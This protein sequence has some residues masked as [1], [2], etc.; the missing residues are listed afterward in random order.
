MVW[1]L[2]KAGAIILLVLLVARRLMPPVLERV[3]RTC[4]P[5]LFLLTVIAICLGTAWLTSVAGVSLSLGAF[6]A[7]LLV[8]E[9]RFSHHAFGEILPLQI[10]FSA[11]FFV[12]VGMLLDVSFLARHLLPVIAVVI[13]VLVVKVV[14][15]AV[16]ARVLGQPL[17]VA[18]ATGLTL[19]Q[20]GEFSFVLDRAGQAVGLSP[21]GLG[22]TGS[23]TFI[24]ASV[25]LMVATPQLTTLASWLAGWHDR[26]PRVSE[27]AV[28][29][30]DASAGEARV[31][32]V[33]Q[34]VIVAGFGQA[35]R[36]LVHVLAGSRIPFV[37]TT[38]SPGGANDAEE[39]GLP[40]LRGDYARPHTLLAAGLT[41]ARLLVVVDDEPAMAHRVLAVARSIAPEVRLVART[42]YGSEGASLRAAGADLVVT[43]ELESVVQVFAEIMRVYRVEPAE[44]ERHAA[45]IRDRGYAAL[46]DLEGDRPTVDCSIDGACEPARSAN[47]SEAAMGS[48]ERTDIDPQQTVTLVPSEGTCG[49][50]AQL[51]AVHPSARGCE[52]CLKTGDTWVHLRVC[53]TCGH[54]GCCD[55]SPNTHATR[56]FHATAHPIVRSLERG[57][58][59][60][61]CYV[62][63]VML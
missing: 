51:H 29:E 32:H 12:S 47:L 1:A 10:L 61:W 5:E 6:L 39:A 4:S 38:L 13:G 52:D 28:E 54:V 42:R 8:S 33:T 9:S 17:A 56:H 46:L 49:H 35:A 48:R 19:A 26:L 44:I 20:I 25:T 41:R 36:L 31:A 24:A 58:Q 14:T 27:T 18:A 11:A 50:V 59:W 53:M 60:G 62:D 43:E 34:H 22:E 2:A 16:S 3:A 15:T 57:E 21:A 7:G 63:E 30:A 40:V 55:S 37:I 45:T 23:Q